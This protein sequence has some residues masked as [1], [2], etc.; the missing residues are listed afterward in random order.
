[1]ENEHGWDLVN[2]FSRRYSKYLPSLAIVGVAFNYWGVFNLD[3]IPL[4]H[5]VDILYGYVILN[6][7][8]GSLFF[9]GKKKEQ[10]T[11]EI[12]PK[13]KASLQADIHF[14]C[15]NCGKLEYKPFDKDKNLP[16]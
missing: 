11:T 9:F 6:G 14:I 16:L 10:V 7:L 13:C 3:K 5:F 15:P 12:C 1:M 2:R 8:A 4:P